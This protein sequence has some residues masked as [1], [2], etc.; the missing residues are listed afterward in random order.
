MTLTE[1]FDGVGSFGYIKELL[2]MKVN[3]L[4]LLSVWVSED[5][6]ASLTL[7]KMDVDLL[8]PISLGCV[9]LL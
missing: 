9:H 2:S 6:I 7:L 8:H 4:H 5:L 3:C 1:S